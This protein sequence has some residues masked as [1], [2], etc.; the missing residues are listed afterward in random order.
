M[1]P[2]FKSPDYN[3]GWKRIKSVA[4]ENR[5]EKELNIKLNSL[6]DEITKVKEDFSKENQNINELRTDFSQLR[7]L[8]NNITK[9]QS[10]IE[11]K[12][13]TT[14]KIIKEEIE[15]VKIKDEQYEK[16]RVINIIEEM[17]RQS[18]ADILQMK[19]EIENI[20]KNFE[21][22]KQLINNQLFLISEILQN[23]RESSGK[24]VD[25][26]GFLSNIFKK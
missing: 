22:Y 8:M 14:E 24:Q 6:K 19:N 4:D 21:E 13:I 7:A 18:D 23:I 15:K 12:L 11:E 25:K 16:N 3:S 10:D 1:E 9:K 20:K 17:Q 2:S 5:V 26:S